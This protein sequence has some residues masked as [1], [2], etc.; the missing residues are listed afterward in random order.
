MKIFVTG[1]TGFI[2]SA[3]V[4]EL[5]RAGHQV[6]G[7]ARSEE[8]AKAL[9]A[10]GA[11][12]HRGDLKDLESLKS[13]AAASEGV[14]H[15]GF[16]HDF[17]KFQENCE[18]DKNAI[19]AMGEA[20]AGTSKPILVTSGTA[21]VSPGTLALEIVTPKPN[22]AWPR[23]SE[24][25]ADELAAKGINARV[26]R[27][28]PSVHGDGDH[29][30]VP[31]L[32]HLAREKG[33]SAYI[34]EGKNRWTG[35]HRLDAAVLYRLALEKG[36]GGTRYHGADEEGVAFKDI[37]AAIGKGLNLPVESKPAEHF[38]WFAN[39]AGLDCPA[40]SQLTRESLGWRPTHTGLLADLEKG[41]Y[42]KN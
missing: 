3:T 16:I 38:G 33:V 21:L 25:A 22:P 19:R 32:I 39:F 14:I 30:F 20:L 13:G 29:G 6:L 7:L 12:V 1:A 36:T 2:G 18:I 8:G 5:I 15:L 28:S 26:V 11:Q 31:M 17:T 4:Q 9:A 24:H 10:A 27:L 37:A 42:F 35:V 34:G 40:S 23:Y 41:T